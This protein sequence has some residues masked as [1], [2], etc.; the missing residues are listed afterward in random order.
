[1]TVSPSFFGLDEPFR[2]SPSESEAAVLFS[3]MAL[4]LALWLI[5]MATDKPEAWLSPGLWLILRKYSSSDIPSSSKEPVYSSAARLIDAVPV[6]LCL[7]ARDDNR[8]GFPDN[9]DPSESTDAREADMRLGALPPETGESVRPRPRCSWYGLLKRREEP[10]VW[11]VVGMLNPCRAAIA[12]EPVSRSTGELTR[13]SGGE[14]GDS[15]RSSLNFDN[16]R[17]GVADVD[18]KVLLVC[19]GG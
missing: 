14:M 11:I 17:T 10:S 19:E 3:A 8:C 13:E 16:V 5:P 4:L 18:R 1:M 7:R 2:I 15:G 9:Q 6:L 12:F